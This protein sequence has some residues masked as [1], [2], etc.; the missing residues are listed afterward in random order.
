MELVKDKKEPTKKVEGINK[1]SQ[2]PKSISNE[3]LAMAAQQVFEQN[4]QLLAENQKLRKVEEEM[5]SLN[6]YRRLDYLLV[7]LRD[8]N[9][10]LLSNAFKKKC[11]EEFEMLMTP[12]EAE[13]GDK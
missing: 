1:T 9:L 3:E 12:V 7:V 4:K 11:A 8:K 2:M 10:T 6:F 13:Q 5:N